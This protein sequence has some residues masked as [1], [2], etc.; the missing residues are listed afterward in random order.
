[1]SEPAGPIICAHCGKPFELASFRRKTEEPEATA[2]PVRSSSR[3][4]RLVKCPHCEWKFELGA[5]EAEPTRKPRPA[6]GRFNV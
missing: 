3:S 4:A 1:M 5:A 2:Q 6:R